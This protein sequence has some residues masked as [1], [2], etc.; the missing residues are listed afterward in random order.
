MSFRAAV[1]LGSNLGDRLTT[2]RAAVAALGELGDLEAVSSL[3]ETAPVGGPE[4]GPYLN[5]VAV[6]STRL[7]PVA[8]LSDL[9]RIETE[10]GRVRR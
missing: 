5:A 9:L 4:Q 10:Q 6:L 1:A 8:L 7:N 2:L 3:Y